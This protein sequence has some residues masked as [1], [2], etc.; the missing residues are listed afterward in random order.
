MGGISDAP[1]LTIELHGFLADRLERLG[2]RRGTRVQVVVSVRSG[3]RARDVLERLVAADEHCALLYDPA[4][5]RFPEH[6]EAVLNGRV[7]DLQGGLDARVEPGDV[8]ALLP[9]HA[10]G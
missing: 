2:R 7:I 1:T 10:G 9:A 8:L 3:E 4:A 6:V 5:G